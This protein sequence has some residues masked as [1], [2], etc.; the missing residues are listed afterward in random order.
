MAEALLILHNALTLAAEG[1]AIHTGLVSKTT[2]F[3]VYYSSREFKSLGSLCTK[4]RNS[5]M[6]GVLFTEQAIFPIYN[7]AS[8]FPRWA[9]NA[10]IRLKS[11][12]TNRILP[13]CKVHDQRHCVWQFSHADICD[14]E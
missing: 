8:T 11:C 1:K 13:Q 6:T 2:L 14:P 4:N 3:P 5:R 10:E 7:M 9:Y 12:F